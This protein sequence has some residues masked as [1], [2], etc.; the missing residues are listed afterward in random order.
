MND[1]EQQIR[2]RV[3]DWMQATMRGDVE[4][5]L[6][7]IA[8][9]ALFL[10]PGHAPISKED[11]AET[12]RAMRGLRFTIDY[13]IREVVVVGDLAYCWNQLEVT[14][15]LRDEEEPHRRGGN[16]LSVW[17]RRD[18]AWLLVRDANQLTDLK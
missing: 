15:P 4:S 9:D 3:D 17:R 13:A 8:E 10:L 11:F 12:Q 14:I 16:V 2:R 7:L 5:V 1:D 18:G 6:G